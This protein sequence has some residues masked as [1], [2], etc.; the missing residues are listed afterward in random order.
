MAIKVLETLRK[1][2]RFDP[3]DKL[4]SDHIIIKILNVHNNN[5]TIKTFKGLGDF[6]SLEGKPIYSMTNSNLNNIFLVI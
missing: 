5:K 4:L 1:S 6:F 2:N 3:R